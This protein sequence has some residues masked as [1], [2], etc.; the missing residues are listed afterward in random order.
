MTLLTYM[1]GNPVNTQFFDPTG[2]RAKISSFG[3]RNRQD[4]EINAARLRIQ[5]IRLTRKLMALEWMFLT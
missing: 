2:Q 3:N 4:E 1:T 5:W